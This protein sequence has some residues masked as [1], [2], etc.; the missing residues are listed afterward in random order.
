MIH[1]V[2]GVCVAGY[3]TSLKTPLYDQERFGTIS[4]A[5]LLAADPAAPIEINLS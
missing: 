5:C 3:A 4:N 2:V 1:S